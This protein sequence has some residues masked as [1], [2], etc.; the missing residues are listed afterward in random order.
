[1]L[2]SQ[3]KQDQFRQLNLYKKNERL[4]FDYD[5]INVYSDLSNSAP[6]VNAFQLFHHV[7]FL[8]LFKTNRYG[9]LS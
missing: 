6:V 8:F 2:V 9:E 3:L 7:L 4:F 1:M 5:L